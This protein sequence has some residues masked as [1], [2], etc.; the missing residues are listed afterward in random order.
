MSKK[1]KVNY[2]GNYSSI[3]DFVYRNSLQ[4]E[5]DELFGK[6]WEPDN[7][8]ENIQLLVGDKYKVTTIEVKSKR[9]ERADDYIVVLKI[10]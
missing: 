5:A 4:K 7:D 3:S 10:S 6:G 2:V 8:I 1:I 9:D